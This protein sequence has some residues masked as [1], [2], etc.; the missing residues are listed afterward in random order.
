MSLLDAAP[1]VMKDPSTVIRAIKA[2]ALRNYRGC[3]CAGLSPDVARDLDDLRAQLVSQQELNRPVVAAQ[4]N[5]FA[6]T[7]RRRE[8]SRRR[9]ELLGRSDG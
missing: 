4:H 3:G 2:D 5:L 9:P 6:C 1:R 7:E 8:V